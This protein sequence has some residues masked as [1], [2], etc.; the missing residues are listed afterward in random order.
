MGMAQS[1]DGQAA[2][3]VEVAPSVRIPDVAALATD[4]DRLR[5]PEGVHH[6]RA[7]ALGDGRRGAGRQLALQ[8]AHDQLPVGAGSG[9][10]AAVPVSGTTIVPMPAS[11]KISSSSGCGTRPSMMVA[12]LTPAST[13]R[14]HASIFGIM[15]AA[16]DG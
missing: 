16:S 6:H 7:V 14:W 2:E 1:V 10:K 15:P 13:A 11:V 9:G 5:R 12:R 4:E 3:H 8:F